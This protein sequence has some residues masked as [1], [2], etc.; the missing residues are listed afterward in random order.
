[1]LSGVGLSFAIPTSTSEQSSFPS[2]SIAFVVVASFYCDT[3]NFQFF[4][5]SFNF[6]AYNPVQV[7]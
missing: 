7:C 4:V 6:L 5:N 3:L 2:S 1:M